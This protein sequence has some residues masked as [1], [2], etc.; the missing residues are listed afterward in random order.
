LT[1]FHA[2]KKYNLE[3]YTRKGFH[4]KVI[5]IDDVDKKITY[6]GSANFL[7]SSSSSSEL[8]VRI[9]GKEVMDKILNKI[10]LPRD[11]ERY[12]S[13]LRLDKEHI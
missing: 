5:I 1:E 6:I 12:I 11:E 10:G 7:S 8:I 9:D 4:E 13:Q 2:N 3:V